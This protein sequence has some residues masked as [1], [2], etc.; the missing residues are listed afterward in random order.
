[1]QV[2]NSLTLAI[3]FYYRN[4]IQHH[5]IKMFYGINLSLFFVSLA[6]VA[7]DEGLVGISQLFNSPYLLSLLLLMF[8]MFLSKQTLRYIWV[9]YAQSTRKSVYRY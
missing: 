5:H 8:L 4:R 9:F 1:M 3:M 6:F 7:E 2:F